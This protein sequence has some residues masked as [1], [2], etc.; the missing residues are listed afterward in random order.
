MGSMP[1]ALAFVVF[2][3]GHLN[4]L[5]GEISAVKGTFGLKGYPV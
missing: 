3:T 1:L 4:N 2:V 5:C